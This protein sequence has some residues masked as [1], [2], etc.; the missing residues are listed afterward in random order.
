MTKTFYGN[1]QQTHFR[2]SPGLRITFSYYGPLC[3]TPIFLLVC[4]MLTDLGRIEDTLDALVIFEA[5]RQGV[6]P[7]LNRRLVA[8]E[9]GEIRQQPYDPEAPTLS[10][11]PPTTSSSSSSGSSKHQ[12]LA[13][14]VPSPPPPLQRSHFQSQNLI[15]PGSVFVFDETEAKICRWT[16]GRI[17]SPSRICGNFLVYHELYRKL[18]SQKC[19]SARDKAGV[20]DGHGLKDMAL[21]KKVE[22]DGLVV[23]GSRKG[24]FVLKKDG[25]IKKTICVKGISLPPPEKMKGRPLVVVETTTAPPKMGRGRGAKTVESRVPRLNFT[26]T[27]H[28]ICYEQAGGKKRYF[29]NMKLLQMVALLIDRHIFYISFPRIAMAGLYRPRDYVELREI[30]MSKT[31]ITS[32]KFRDPVQVKPL[33]AGQKPVEPSDEYI[34]QTRITEVRTPSKAIMPSAE[35]NAAQ[36]ASATTRKESDP[37]TRLGRKRGTEPKPTTVLTHP[38]PTRGQDRQLREVLEESQIQESSDSE[39][40]S[41]SSLPDQTNEGHAELFAETTRRDPSYPENTPQLYLQPLAQEQIYESNRRE[42]DDT[43]EGPSGQTSRNAKRHGWARAQD[44]GTN[45]S[46]LNREQDHE[47]PFRR[48]DNDATEGSSSN[49]S[50]V[51][52]TNSPSLSSSLTLSPAT[53]PRDEPRALYSDPLSP[54]ESMSNSENMDM[55]MEEA[56][57]TLQ[58]ASTRTYFSPRQCSIPNGTYPY[59]GHFGDASEDSIRALLFE[60]DPMTPSYRLPPYDAQGRYTSNNVYPPPSGPLAYLEDHHYSPAVSGNGEFRRW[61]PPYPPPRN[62]Y[63]DRHYTIPDECP[64]AFVPNYMMPSRDES[65]GAGDD[66]SSSDVVSSDSFERTPVHHEFQSKQ[67]FW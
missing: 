56:A 45:E 64:A 41:A 43:M 1:E 23:L 54:T 9:K 31:F 38:Y 26:G 19:R 35:G 13:R 53:A 66:Y 29:F 2:R 62:Y 30:S 21:R 42:Y 44:W 16:D 28:L 8:A 40:R 65:Y 49:S 6:L 55:D 48:A 57:Q 4:L 11:T 24:T 51:T 12:T 3:L 14:K 59:R 5:C 37:A 15:T 61:Y 33:P 27:Q 17:W 67:M 22:Q 58:Q 47:R 36:S 63:G 39:S 50:P 34:S 60:P 18:P 32:Q 46:T 10:I 52:I 7:K 20:R 25:L